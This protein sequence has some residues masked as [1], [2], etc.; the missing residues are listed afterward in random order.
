MSKKPILPFSTYVVIVDLDAEVAKAG[1][2]REAYRELVQAHIDSI[3]MEEFPGLIDKVLRVV[4]LWREMVD[5]LQSRMPDK[6]SHLAVIK[7]DA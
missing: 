2:A 4:N 1:L 3:P 7:P 5:E 6:R